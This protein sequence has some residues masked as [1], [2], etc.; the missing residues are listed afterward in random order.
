[1]VIREAS[2]LFDSPFSFT[3]LKEKGD[4]FFRGASPLS[5][6]LIMLLCREDSS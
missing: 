2:P 1:M 5:T 4:N 3:L 6:L